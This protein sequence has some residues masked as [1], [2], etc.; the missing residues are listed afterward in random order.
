MVLRSYLLF[1]FSIHKN[2]IQYLIN[3]IALIVYLVQIQCRHGGDEKA[4]DVL[5]KADQATGSR[6]TE[7]KSN[8]VP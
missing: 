5:S 8:M 2:L 6:E 4:T 3:D 1:R 7:E